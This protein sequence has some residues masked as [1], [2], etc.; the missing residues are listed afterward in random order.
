MRL[1]RL[2]AL[3]CLLAL[4]FTSC[5]AKYQDIIRDRDET[6]RDLEMQL[7]SARGETT[8]LRGDLS[9]ARSD[10]A[11]ARQSA[12]VKPAASTKNIDELLKEND[13]EGKVVASYRRGG[14]SL[15]VPSS[16]TFSSGSTQISPEGSRVLGK[17]AS[18][19]RREFPGKRIYVEGH[20]DSDPIKKSRK[21]YRS[22]RHLSVERADAVA[23][24]LSGKGLPESRLVIAGFGPHDP[25]ARGN[26]SR[27]RRVEIVVTK[28]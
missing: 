18:L 15:G 2:A 10:L 20:T 16:I 23:T 11:A 5:T 27:N 1:H 14:L 22:N 12:Q 13:L 19:I 4:P 17:L 8:Q 24:F 9:Q 6:I 3:T 26:K 7:S 28:S 25:V 21:R